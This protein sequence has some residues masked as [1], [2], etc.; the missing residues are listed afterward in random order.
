[1]LAVSNSSQK[2]NQQRFR[3]F[4]FLFATT[5]VHE[6]GGH[7]LVTFLGNGRPITPPQITGP[8]YGSVTNGESGR[9]LELN[10]FGGNTEYFHDATQDKGQVKYSPPIPQPNFLLTT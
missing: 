9:F 3:T 10:L 6:V 7:L 8:N 5:F 1:M 4:Q 2:A